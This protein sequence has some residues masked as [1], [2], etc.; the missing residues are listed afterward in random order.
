MN[1][2]NDTI[3]NTGDEAE[4]PVIHL[5]EVVD[6]ADIDSS[7]A[8]YPLTLDPSTSSTIPPLDTFSKDASIL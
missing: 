1:T 6:E 2:M 5:Q 8:E 3:A 7:T 4:D